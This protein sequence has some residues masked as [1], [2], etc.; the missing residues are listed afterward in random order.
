MDG[1]QSKSDTIP[2]TQRLT[3]AEED[4]LIQKV[5]QLDSHGLPIRL[6]TLRDFASAITQGRGQP[7]VGSK[8][9]YNFIQRTPEL[10][11]RMIRSMNYRR[12]LSEDPKLIGEWFDV[13]SNTKA[14]YRICDEDIYNFNK[15][16]F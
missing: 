12:A 3:P 4:M 9:A 11:T 16:G 5:L 8:W 1:T 2:R 14:K 7:R 6:D 10:K 13:I 15:T